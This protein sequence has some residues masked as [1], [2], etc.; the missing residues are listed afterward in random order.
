MT[1]KSFGNKQI[2]R[3]R[4]VYSFNFSCESCYGAFCL[5]HVFRIFFTEYPF[6]F[7]LSMSVT[8]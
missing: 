5:A 1:S 6:S 2:L 4:F 8:F 3:C 7:A